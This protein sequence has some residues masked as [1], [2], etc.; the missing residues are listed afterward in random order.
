M[1]DNKTGYDGGS[2]PY[3]K[4][5]SKTKKNMGDGHMNGHHQNNFNNMVSIKNP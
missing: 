2:S 5:K 3:T 4:S 1:A